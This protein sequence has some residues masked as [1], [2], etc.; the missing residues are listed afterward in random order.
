MPVA[1]ITGAVRSVRMR[2]KRAAGEDQRAKMRSGSKPGIEQ[3]KGDAPLAPH[4]RGGEVCSTAQRRDPFPGSLGYRRLARTQST[5]ADTTRTAKSA[6]GK[7]AEWFYVDACRSHSTAPDWPAGPMALLR[8]VRANLRTAL[9]ACSRITSADHS[10]TVRPLTAHLR[11]CT[12][13]QLPIAARCGCQN[14]YMVL[15]TVFQQV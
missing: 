8:R 11:S 13:T 14:T 15:C 4:S 1:R 3:G 7:V 6:C 5:T 2:D 10:S 9:P 12:S